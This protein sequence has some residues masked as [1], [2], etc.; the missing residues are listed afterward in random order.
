MTYSTIK[1]YNLIK[2]GG[3][4]MENLETKDMERNYSL[5]QTA[6]LLGIKV[7][8]L[9]TWIVNGKIKA[10]KYPCS[11]RWFISESEIRRLRGN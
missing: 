9:R 3:E 1:G 5:A 7:R 2:K 11:N 10:Q 4:I 8:T 6:V